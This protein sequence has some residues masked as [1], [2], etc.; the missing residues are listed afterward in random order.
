MAQM[1]AVGLVFQVSHPYGNSTPPLCSYCNCHQVRHL[2]HNTAKMN[3]TDKHSTPT[4]PA[5]HICGPSPG[6]CWLVALWFS[7]ST[8]FGIVHPLTRK[9]NFHILFN[10]T[11]PKQFTVPN[12]HWPFI[13]YTTK[14][15]KLTSDFHCNSHFLVSRNSWRLVSFTVLS[16][17]CDS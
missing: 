2:P 14:M 17:H 1:T 16:R 10:N 15:S 7:Y 5:H 9:Q 3:M 11:P 4:K 6:E 12:K 13:C 8:Y